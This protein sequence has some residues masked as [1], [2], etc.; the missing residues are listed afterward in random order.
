MVKPG[1]SMGLARFKE[2]K[3]HG[4]YVELSADGDKI[5]CQYKVGKLHGMWVKE[6]YEEGIVIKKEY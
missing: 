4:S 3:M 5:A 6:K 2:N 1:Y